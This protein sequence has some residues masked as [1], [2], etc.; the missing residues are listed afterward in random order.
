M[1]KTI[2]DIIDDILKG[3]GTSPSISEKANADLLADGKKEEAKERYRQRYMIATGYNKIGFEPLA[4]HMVDFGANSGPYLATMK[5]QEILGV[6]V[7]GILGDETLK[8]INGRDIRGINNALIEERVK[9]FARIVQKN[10]AQA[11]FLVDWVNRA[12]EFLM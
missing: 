4:A 9:M 8:A 10:P 6:E 2:D 11:R 12:F 3:K 5:L 1:S 7:D